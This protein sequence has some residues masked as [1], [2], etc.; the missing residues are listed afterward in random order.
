ML[1]GI[2]SLTCACAN[3]MRK[4][5]TKFQFLEI[6]FFISFTDFVMKL[7]YVPYQYY[8]M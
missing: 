1:L 6:F 5:L 7:T 4:T 8:K 3:F 2:A